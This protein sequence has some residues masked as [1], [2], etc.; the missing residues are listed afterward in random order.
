VEEQPAVGV[1]GVGDLKQRLGYLG[2]AILLIGL[3]L[4]LVAVPAIGSVNFF[5]SGC[6]G[7]VAMALLVAGTVVALA[8]RRYWAL[9]L[10]GTAS[11]LLIVFTLV[12]V[13]VQSHLHRLGGAGSA[14]GSFLEG[15][16]AVLQA[17][18]TEA[19]RLQ[20]GWPVLLIGSSLIVASAEAGRREGVAVPRVF[21]DLAVATAI[22]LGLI[23]FGPAVFSGTQRAVTD[24]QAEKRLV[25][26]ER[27]VPHQ[28][29]RQ[30]MA[31]VIAHVRDEESD[32]SQSEADEA[33]REAEAAARRR[34]EERRLAQ[35]RL[36]SDIRRWYP[37]FAA[38]LRPVLEARQ[39]FLD[40]YA[41]G[42]LACARAACASIA[43]QVENARRR[44]PTS[45]DRGLDGVTS[46]LF[47]LYQAS[48]DSCRNEGGSGAALADF[49]RAEERI[50]VQLEALADSLAV[51]C[52]AVPAGR[53]GADDRPASY[54]CARAAS[55]ATSTARR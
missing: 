12:R 25:E 29:A 11:L 5:W 15:L 24:Y 46:G 20:W 32:R 40:D 37:E 55:I 34:A 36:V 49:E 41:A 17:G 9:W 51:Y 1:A 54:G 21:W 18:A 16:G 35:I 26:H 44:F 7:G 13:A 48:A 43:E 52:L 19:M 22:A 50:G 53:R 3:F 47:D 10:T 30:E 28:S 2:A 14:E 31:A 23:V 8:T 39:S 27:W 6:A 33:A 42:G 38:S 4:P 45:P